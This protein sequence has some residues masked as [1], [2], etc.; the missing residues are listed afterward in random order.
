M[1]NCYLPPFMLTTT[2]ADDTLMPLVVFVLVYAGRLL[3]SG[4]L[5]GPRE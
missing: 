4:S 5:R 2:L 3:Y 1:N